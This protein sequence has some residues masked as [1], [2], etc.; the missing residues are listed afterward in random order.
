MEIVNMSKEELLKEIEDKFQDTIA[1]ISEYDNKLCNVFKIVG[2]ENDELKHSTFTRWLL[3]NNAFFERFLSLCGI[4]L[5]KGQIEETRKIKREE[6][7]GIDELHYN[8]IKKDLYYENK[9]GRRIDLNIIGTTY[10]ITIEN[11][12]DTGEHNDQCLSYYN[13]MMDPEGKYKEIKNKYFVFLAKNDI[14]NFE[15][16]GGLI[17][18]QGEDIIEYNEKVLIDNLERIVQLKANDKGIIELNNNLRFATKKEDAKKIGKQIEKIISNIDKDKMLYFNYRLFRYEDILNIMK[19]P[20]FI[21]DFIDE[22]KKNN[23]SVKETDILFVKEI[24]HQ[25]IKLIE[26]WI[27]MPEEYRALF[28]NMNSE[29]E[30]CFYEI[31]NNYD[32]L[33]KDEKDS[34]VG[35]FLENAKKYYL[36]RKGNLDKRIKKILQELAGQDAKLDSYNPKYAYSLKTPESCKIANTIDYS[37]EYGISVDMYVGLNNSISKGLLSY[38]KNDENF[39]EKLNAMS[40]SRMSILVKK[41]EHGKLCELDFNIDMIVKDIPKE[42]KERKEYIKK[43]FPIEIMGYK[44]INPEAA[45]VAKVKAGKE[46]INNKPAVMNAK[47]ENIIIKYINDNAEYF[48]KDQID[49]TVELIKKYQEEN[50]TRPEAN[51]T[52]LFV[53]AVQNKFSGDI[54]SDENIK[55][56]FVEATKSELELIGEKIEDMFVVQ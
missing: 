19:N 34:D 37:A 24:L 23:D 22:F 45:K 39:F 6:S 29:Q 32:I 49:R 52:S 36:E 11:K 3:S 30:E 43:L 20:Q 50:A 1:K 44:Y 47:G 48:K 51:F 54:E 55:K 5:T 10:S 26:E 56:F 16:R 15:E 28:E 35:R 42:K 18:K 9:S 17:R 33:Y 40:G 13:Y 46:K 38:I 27:Q 31:I 7:Y 53:V 21:N 41:G 4:K 2:C 25:Y 12:I 8:P 14:E